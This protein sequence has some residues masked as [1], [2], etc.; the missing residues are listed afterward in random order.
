MREV[1]Y[2]QNYG[3]SRTGWSNGGFRNVLILL[4]IHVIIL[5]KYLENP[6]PGLSLII[7]DHTWQLLVNE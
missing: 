7:T 3:I 5:Y 4:D 2:R 1:G 6:A